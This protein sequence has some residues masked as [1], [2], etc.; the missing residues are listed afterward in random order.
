MS[1]RIIEC[2]IELDGERVARLLPNLRLSLLDRLAEAFDSI[3]EDADYIA[4]LEERLETEA[5][6]EEKCCSESAPNQR[7]KARQE[8]LLRDSRQRSP[9][10]ASEIREKPNTFR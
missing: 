6:G 7:L 3:E 8:T 4:E 10:T 9:V 2:W 1:L 5:A